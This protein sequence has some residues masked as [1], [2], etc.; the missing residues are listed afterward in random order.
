MKLFNFARHLLPAKVAA[1][2]VSEGD[3]KAAVEKIKV[4]VRSHPSVA[5]VGPREHDDV[6][7]ERLD[8]KDWGRGLAFVKIHAVGGVLGAAL[9][10][11]LGL[12]FT[13]A[14]PELTQG[15]PT[16]ALTAFTY[17][18]A[19]IGLI[20]AG[21]F[22]FR[23]DQDVLTYRALSAKHQGQWVV[24]YHCDRRQDADRIKVQLAKSAEEVIQ[25]C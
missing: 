17:V 5:I 14:G 24:I 13:L 21:F 22:S 25:T 1:F 8:K 6:L 4:S 19:F 16:F 20:G 3:A 18:G 15:D 9:G 7:A 12:V 11:L 23:L 10:A 2:F